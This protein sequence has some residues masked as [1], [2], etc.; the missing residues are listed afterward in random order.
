MAQPREYFLIV[1][2]DPLICDLVGRQS[3][4][5]AGYRV[6]YA[7]DVPT[8]IANAVQTLP[9]VILCDLALEGLSSKDLLVALQAQGVDIPVVLIAPKGSEADLIQNFR[10]GA[11][12]YLLWPAREPEVLAVAERVLKQVR[13]RRARE[14]L[15]QA[16]QHTNQEL[17]Q[18][19]DELQT[20]FNIAKVLTSLTHQ[21]VLFEQL[22]EQLIKTTRS[23]LGWV[24]LKD[25]GRKALVLTAG[26][27]L[28]ASL[29][30]QRNRPWEDGVSGLVALS[31][32]SLALHGEPLKRFRI[33]A[34]GQAAL[35]VPIKA[36]QQVIGIVVLMR[37][38]E[39]PYQPAQQRLVE[40]VA[41]FASISLANARLFRTLEE[42]VRLQQALMESATLRVRVLEQTLQQ[43][44]LQMRDGI[45]R[46]FQALES[47]S[48]DPTARWSP[49]QRQALTTWRESL[50][51][52]RVLA[53]LIP[54]G[55][56]DVAVASAQAQDF[57]ALVSEAV[58]HLSPLV[59]Q[60][61][62]E[63]TLASYPQPLPVNGDEA[64]LRYVLE[65][66]LT[67]AIGLS[68]SGQILGRISEQQGEAHLEVELQAELDDEQ[69]RALQKQPF[70]GGVPMPAR[71]PRELTPDWRLIQQ[72]LKQCQGKIWLEFVAAQSLRWHVVF[73]LTRSSMAIQSSPAKATE[74]L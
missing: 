32:E 72:I 73:P 45:E 39:T 37:K 28:P 29:M 57:N 16:L 60:R 68:E 14:Q 24:L 44:R 58:R 70:E 47:L 38:K 48:K 7:M 50:D 23:D 36:S 27:H 62:Q 63:I 71:F 40:A 61:R 74:I 12:D 52:L 19:L 31:G 8:A 49:G 46:Q 30:A 55:S 69:R 65:G 2:S 6:E 51:A 10:L 22:L 35:I 5:A 15:A 1:E 26:K 67:L 53:G 3:L 33:A 34:L 21:G 42:R 18:R 54:D 4:Q 20:I 9:D 41:D 64:L 13:E 25:E 11:V 66:V 17:Q 43:V 56:R 59:Q